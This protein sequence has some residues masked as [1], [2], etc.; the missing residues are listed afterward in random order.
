MHCFLGPV[1]SCRIPG[2]T[3]K[4]LATEVTE[5]TEA[6]TKPKIRSHRKGAKVAKKVEVK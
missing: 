5:N 2:E 4:R 6:E 3:F 1:E